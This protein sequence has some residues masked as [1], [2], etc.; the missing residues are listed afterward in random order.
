MG[1]N[2]AG[3]KGLAPPQPQQPGIIVI[4]IR[5]YPQFGFAV[6]RAGAEGADRIIQFYHPDG[7]RRDYPFEAEVAKQ[8]SERILA[9]SVPDAGGVVLGA[10]GKPA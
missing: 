6:E 9:P 1:S 8:L 10:D 5:Q 7:I 3:K 4:E 2:T